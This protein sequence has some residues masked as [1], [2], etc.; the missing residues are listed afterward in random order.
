M[1]LVG[2]AA[3]YLLA[4]GSSSPRLDAELLLAEVLGCQRMDLYMQFDRPLI[5]SELVRF[6]ELC[7]RRAGGEPIAYI[8]ERREF[9]SLEFR[10]SP[11]V[12]VPRPETEVLVSE[13][14]RRLTER[15]GEG[16]YRGLDVGTGS[17]A[18][19][20]ALLV[21][22]PNLTMVATEISPAAVEVAT[23]NAERHGVSDRLEIRVVDLVDGVT[24][25]FDVVCAN[26]P[27][28]D[29]DW[30]DAVDP[31]VRASEPHIALF[32]GTNGMDLIGRLLP[33]LPRLLLPGGTG[34]VEIDPRQAEDATARAAEI[35][36]VNVIS[37]LAG[38]ERLLVI[39]R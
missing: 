25:P 21:A 23:G 2:K 15:G 7:R 13:A 24:G 10:V 5:D 22:V 17:G 6:R 26:L 35:G 14:V 29:P 19:A 12:L 18:I 38:R 16:V 9:M 27:Y 11:D 39:R 28:I 20:I 36:D 30:P 31:S 3:P 33:E 32:A 4:H 34:Y 37:D 1:E 8:R